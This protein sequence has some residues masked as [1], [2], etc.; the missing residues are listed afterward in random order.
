ME[1]LYL[2]IIYFSIFRMPLP[3]L[4]LLDA[5]LCLDPTR[6]IASEQALNCEWLR[7][8]YNMVPPMLPH[9]QDCHEMWSKQ[10]RRKMAQA[11]SSNGSDLTFH[12]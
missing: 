7:N 3:A 8:N 4:D 2:F 6:R 5:M 10:R 1:N 12:Y 9:D 11:S